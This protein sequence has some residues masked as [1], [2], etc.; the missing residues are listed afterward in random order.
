MDIINTMGNNIQSTT[1]TM[2][3]A[4]VNANETLVQGTSSQG[5]SAQGTSS[6]GTSSQGTS[7]Q[8]TS[9]QGTDTQTPG[10]IFTSIPS[11]R[12]GNTLKEIYTNSYHLPIGMLQQNI[13]S[14]TDFELTVPAAELLKTDI[15]GFDIFKIEL[16]ANPLF[17][18]KYI[19]AFK[20]EF[21]SA[22]LDTNVVSDLF[23]SAKYNLD[24][25][26]YHLIFYGDFTNNENLLL[27]NNPA[28]F[29]VLPMHSI[30]K[31]H[32]GANINILNIDRALRFVDQLEARISFTEVVFNQSVEDKIKSYYCFD[33]YY[34]RKDGTCN[35][36]RM[37]ESGFGSVSY[38]NDIHPCATNILP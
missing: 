7:T 20:I 23:Q 22:T 19:S 31:S 30:H 5:T 35:V 25:G 26:P 21:V 2:E 10:P 17:N 15:Y 37:G 9:A 11:G 18:K 12:T 38:A 29:I 14:K 16:T 28:N 27:S 24:L 3:S 1:A 32:T 6:Q 4:E 34:E 13:D 8:G 33:Q 36:F